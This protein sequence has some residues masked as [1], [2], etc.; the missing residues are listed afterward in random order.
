MGAAAEGRT[1]FDVWRSA[2]ERGATNAAFLANENRTWREVSWREADERIDDLAAGF[3][4]LG[5]QKGDKVAIL[6]R[7][8][9]E[10][11]LCDYAL[12][13]IGAIVV[14]IYQTNSR[15]ECR[16]VVADSAARALICEDPE[17]LEKTAGFGDELP[18]LELTLAF[19]GAMGDA[20]ALDDVAARGRAYAAEKPDALAD[21]RESVSP[22]DVLT[23]IYTSGTTGDPKGCVLTHASWAA[24]ID[25]L[26]RTDGL[27][28]RDDVVLLFLPLAHNFARLV[29][30][31]GA[32]IGFT[33]ALEPDVNRVARALVQVRPTVFPSVPRLYERV[34]KTLRNRL[35]Q[36]EGVQGRIAKW[37]LGVGRHAAHRGAEGKR[38]GPLLGLQLRIADRLVFSKVKERFGGRLR[39]GVSGGAPLAAEIIEFFAACGILVLEG[40]GLTETTSA[41]S[42]N[43]PARYRFGSVGLPVPGVEVALADD[44]EIKIR[45]PGIFQ[46]YFG[47]DDATA[48]V[49]TDDGWLLTGDI[50]T[51]DENGFLTITDRKKELIVTAGGKKISPSNLENELLATGYVS[52][53]FVVGDNR[54]YLAALVYPNQEEIDKV[55]PTESE[56]RELIQRAIDAVNEHHGPVERI[57]RFAILPRDFSAE[58][59]E[60]TPTLKVKRKVVEE[61]F[62]DEIER[63]YRREAAPA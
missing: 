37:A 54:S 12:A 59:G 62:R 18:A 63:L 42:V 61:H 40:Y 26:E 36:A 17:Q 33:L 45:G 58:E 3:L 49:L 1:I 16:Y 10:W 43:R 38:P 29:Q 51:I 50:G 52:S 39:H 9:L 20:I 13:S 6:S 15:D 34:Y 57:H 47:K 4:A 21:A 56:Q 41:V 60:V 55:A 24:V 8:R 48:E 14:P 11:T 2:V 32:Q 31:A 35:E 22:A 7:T 46:G 23:Y 25:S 28:Q 27:I 5:L 19:D 44:D 53:A 30:F